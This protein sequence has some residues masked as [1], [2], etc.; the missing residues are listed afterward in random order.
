M[1]HI[2]NRI[3]LVYINGYIISLYMLFELNQNFNEYPMRK[4]LVLTLA[5]AIWSDRSSFR[6]KKYEFSRKLWWRT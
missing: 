4:I 3:Y 5:T 1:W 2:L 6:G